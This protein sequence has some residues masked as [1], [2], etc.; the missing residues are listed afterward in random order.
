[1]I[2]TAVTEIDIL[3]AEAWALNVD[4][5]VQCRQMSLQAK[6]FCEASGYVSGLLTALRNLC[7]LHIRFHEY[8]AALILLNQA[9]TFLET[10]EYSL[11]PATFQLYLQASAVHNR[12][13]NTP[14]ALT[15]CYQAEGIA[16]KENDAT[17]QALVYKTLG[18]THVTSGE[19]RKALIN[20]EKSLALF[21]EL[22][23]TLGQITVLNNMCHTFHLSD[24]LDESLRT[25]LEGLDLY[26]AHY[27]TEAV[28]KRVYAYNLNNVG[29]AYL[30]Q[31]DFETAVSYFEKATDLFR[32]ESDLYGEIYSLRGLAQVKMHRQQ[33]EEAFTQFNQALALAQ[34]SEI[35]VELVQCHLALANAYKEIN[36]FQQALFHFEKYHESEKNILNDETERRMRDLE[37][38]RQI[39]QARQETELYQLK[40]DALQKEIK[41]RREA[42]AI[43]EAASKTKSEF[44]ANMSHEIRTPLNGI[45]GVI[46]LMQNTPL[47]AQQQELIHIIQKSGDNLLRIVNDVLD[48][49]K[50]EA[51]KLE[52]EHLPFSVRQAVETA[53]DLLTPQAV[54]K[55]LDIGYI[56]EPDVPEWIVGDSLRFQQ[57]LI[58]LLG[59]GL[60]FTDRGS[61][62]VQVASRPVGDKVEIHTVVQDTGIGINII[63]Q[64]RLFQSFSQ[65]DSSVTRKYGG[66]G[67]GLAISKLLAELMGGRMWVKSK[68]E[69]GSAF[70]FTIKAPIAPQTSALSE[71]DNGLANK[72]VLLLMPEGNGRLAIEKQLLSLK[73]SPYVAPDVK[74]AVTL[75]RENDFVAIMLESQPDTLPDQLQNAL[76]P[77]C[78]PL[79]IVT[80]QPENEAAS[81]PV[82][83]FLPKP[84]K[85]DTLRQKLQELAN[86]QPSATAPTNHNIAPLLAQQYPLSILIAE[87]N[88][89]NQKVAR[90]ILS[91]LGY[92][93]ELVE[94]GA[95]AVKRL[96][97][98]PYDVIFMDIQMPEMDGITA[99]QEIFK[100]YA[101]RTRPYIFA[102]TAYA[103]KG[104]REKLL[105]AGM[106]DYISKPV[107]L[108]SL[109]AALKNYIYQKKS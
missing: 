90:K 64:H 70:H 14:Q 102:M 30:K 107:R 5:P 45:I 62:Y 92:E 32:Q 75:F 20:Y 40:N 105:Q 35:A 36:D 82:V 54:G 13:G 18:N 39:Q 106:D 25:G 12:L 8:E 17:R 48:F 21:F 37:S 4:D 55:K 78:P 57:I 47:N 43:A 34:Q 44:L 76:G 31:G 15:Y 67:L 19:Y 29:I 80:R 88:R 89:V 42:E 10:P 60:K 7:E 96:A 41:K 22:N 108:E 28:P 77:T 1:M 85:L 99:T 73:M 33:Y 16:L 100:L 86:Y 6:T 103:M 56:M 51:G 24:H 11:H 98:R 49:S 3:L 84:L 26:E 95:E 2:K 27:Q 109:T 72:K 91:R 59:N 66:T 69:L 23:D 53:V 83:D 93:A 104:D 63:E 50:I 52:L 38:T 61:I 68:P 97:E 74:Q 65:V 101:G 94:N 87:D 9:L 81:T 79:L 58:N 71:N 46:E